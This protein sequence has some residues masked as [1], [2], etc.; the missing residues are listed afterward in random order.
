[1]RLGVIDSQ[2]IPRTTLL[3]EDSLSTILATCIFIVIIIGLFWLDR[4][5]T[6]RTSAALWIPQVWFLLACSRP[7]STWLNSGSEVSLDFATSHISEG[8][9]VDRAVGTFLLLLALIVLLGRQNRVR[10]SLR[11][12]WPLIL[13][14]VYC[15]VSV[16]WSEFPQIAM[17]R[18][19]RVVGDWLMVL[20]IWTDAQPIDALTILLARLSYTLIP[21]SILFSK[22]FQLGRE[23]N[24]WMGE[25]AYIGVTDNKNTLG[26][27]C[28]L[29]GIASVWQALNLHGDRSKPH[30]KRYL[31][32]Q[33]AVFT[34]VAYLLAKADSVTSISCMLLVSGS[35][36]A[37]RF[38]IFSRRRFWVHSI[39]FVTLV[40]PVFIAFFGTLMP[41]VLHSMGR[42]ATLTDRTLIWAWVIKLVPNDW[43]GTGF[44]SFWLGPR[45]NVMIENVTHVWVPNQAHNGYLEVFINLGWIGV[46]L[47]A[48][49]VLWGYFRIIRAWRQKR[50]A[51][52]LM[53]AYF[54]IG[55]ITNLSEA[56]FFRE[57]VPAWL[58]FLV[59]ITMPPTT[60]EEAPEPLIDSRERTHRQVAR[61]FEQDPAWSVR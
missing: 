19:I 27:I 16:V 60:V 9:P 49:V 53:L 31:L 10:L 1:M 21:L 13:F 2:R 45:L 50:P 4:E 39:V 46:A 14:F 58:F 56:S 5:R 23:Y 26:A 55:M 40:I 25:T 7:I 59:A 29:L 38:Q 34:M 30:R 37:L 57:L 33:L 6:T 42:S 41:G 36:L 8:S 22:Y 61:T 11:T 51:S 48:L 17:K 35:M 15:V 3:S 43:I 12:C 28:L 54:L 52:D 20:V 32:V 18:L 44:A 47:L 24:F